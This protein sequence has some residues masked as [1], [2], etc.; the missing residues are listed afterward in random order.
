M[1]EQIFEAEPMPVGAELVP[2]RSIPF[3]NEAEQSVLGAMFLD[4]QKIPDV[5][6]IVSAEDFYVA[7]HRELF[8]AMTDLYNTGKPID[9]VS[10]KECL[11]Q[12]GS[13]EKIGG[14]AFVLEV[15][16][17]VPTTGNAE[18]YAHIVESKSMLRKMIRLSEQISE[19]CYGG[20][21]TP[22][23][24]IA[25][26]ERE[27]M[28]VVQGQQTSGLTHIK[29]FLGGCVDRITSLSDNQEGM[30]GLTTGFVDLDRHMSGLI[31][32]DLI[33]IAARPGMGKTS[34]A[35]NI[36]Q[37]AALK[38]KVPVAVFNLEMTGE[39]LASRMLSGE[40][41][42]SSRRLRDGDLLDDD[43]PLIGE[44]VT[45][46]SETEIYIDD[47]RGITVGQIGTRCKK[48]KMER[49]LGL[50]VIDY[51]QLIKGTRRDGNRRL[52]IEEITRSLKIL[53]KDLNV[54][55][56]AL[57]QLSRAV[58]KEKREEKR[59]KL[60]DLRES[61]SIEQ[62]ADIVMF[63]HRPGKDDP[64]VEEPN[65]AICIIE[66][67]RNG[68]PADI[69]LTWLGEFTKFGNWSGAREQ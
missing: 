23:E 44:A 40:A 62:D 31:A 58:E 46:L 50:V 28:D 6:Q 35:M 55:L 13:L 60:S 25:D 10:L 51:I 4:M 33:V 2:D 47:T 63:L 17:L 52:E 15:A 56:I 38:A 49:G 22:E 68:E 8:E 24:V 48:L 39:Q 36:A 53:A 54:P 61:G 18:F 57:S 66:K 42:V 27:L 69:P 5:L 3:S 19:S 16:N 67:F 11:T 12:R 41:R 34:F 32:P 30:T 26:T 20:V 9:I 14:L 37:N 29:T 43:W 7:R 21:K 59:P 45:R 65:K 1:E 64:S